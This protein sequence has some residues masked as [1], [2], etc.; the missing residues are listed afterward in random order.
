MYARLIGVPPT[1]AGEFLDT[2]IAWLDGE[3]LF[4]VPPEE[5]DDSAAGTEQPAGAPV[6][7]AMFAVGPVPVRVVCYD[8]E[9][10]A[11]VGCLAAPARLPPDV[12]GRRG[13]IGTTL[14][15]YAAG[16]RYVVA[17]D[18]RPVRT[19]PSRPWARWG[20]IR[21]MVRSAHYRQRQFAA[22]LHAAAVAPRNGKAIVIAGDSGD[23]KSTLCAALVAAGLGYLADDIVPLDGETQTVWP[24]PLAIS[25]KQGSWPVAAS[26]FP[27]FHGAPTSQ[28]GNVACRFWW[29][30][31]QAVPVSA[32]G[33]LVDALVFPH[34]QPGAPLSVADVTPADA[35]A[36]LGNTGSVLPRTSDEL[37]VF[38][39]WLE[40]VP[41]HEL[42]YG[43]LDDAIAAVHQIGQGGE[44]RWGDCGHV[45]SRWLVGR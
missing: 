5:E 19:Y 11:T 7:D 39:A 25:V 6:L 31:D 24:V 13:A 38:L 2:V 3:G 32:G 12:Q 36:I 28:V 21:Q 20:L 43:Y 8:A 23:G 42:T 18:G 34:Y 9:I 16:D 45:R 37:A 14:A 40:R 29:P 35:L 17:V 27:G 44:E 26:L 4:S 33:M 1:V 22:L 41:A 30:G 10:A 15:I